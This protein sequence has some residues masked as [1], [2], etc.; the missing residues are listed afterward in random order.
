MSIGGR[1]AD[2]RNAQKL[3][4]VDFAE[5]LGVPKSSYKNY[6]RGAFD[7]PTALIVSLCEKYGADA[8]WLLLGKNKPSADDLNRVSA[9]ITFAFEYLNERGEPLNAPNLIKAVATILNMLDDLKSD[10]SAV[11]PLLNTIFPKEI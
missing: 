7:P 5:L 8:N 11:R 6:E 1:I 3:N 9:S 10:F 4:Q 2:I